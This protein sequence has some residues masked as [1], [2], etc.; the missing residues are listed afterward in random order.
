MSD[1]RWNFE[2]APT[3]YDENSEEN[4]IETQE[5]NCDSEP[6]I[7]NNSDNEVADNS[8]NEVEDQPTFGIKHVCR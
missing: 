5:T 7:S 6:Y 2:E 8:D 4:V 3:D 1:S